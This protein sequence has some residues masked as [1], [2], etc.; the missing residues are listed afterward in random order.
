MQKITIIDAPCG[1]GK[2]S[3]AIQLMNQNTETRYIYCTPLLDEITRIK[4]NCPYKLFREPLNFE[5]RKIDDFNRLL[6]K[7]VNI[8]VTHHTLLNSTPETLELIRKGGYTLIL[9][10]ALDVLNDFNKLSSVEKDSRQKINKSDVALMLDTPL[11]EIDDALKVSWIGRTYPKGKFSAVE[12]LAKLGVLYCAQR[13]MMIYIFRPDLFECFN[14]ICVMT[15]LFEASFLRCYFDL[16]KIVYE[17]ESLVNE[18]GI[19][20]TVPY[21]PEI[22]SAFRSTCKRLITVCDCPRLNRGYDD[23]AFST[24]WFEKRKKDDEAIKRLKADLIYFFRYIADAR[25]S[26]SEI[27]WTCPKEN[28]E[29]VKGHSYTRVRRKKI[30]ET[31]TKKDEKKLD[32]FQPLNARGTNDFSDRWALA[33]CYNMF[34]NPLIKHFLRHHG[35]PMDENLF[36]VSCLIQW[37]FRGSIRDGK[38][39]ILYLPSPRMRRILQQWMD[40]EI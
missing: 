26:K 15:Y 8:A 6:T 27:L 9:D 22:D 30:K 17:R 34:L 16:H 1:A 21:D 10:E 12:Q 13:Q 14:E 40:G 28:Y 20:W 38:P 24:T 36:A 3:W 7:G 33:Y 37:I 35:I 29:M 11:I 18:N 5:T 39:I 23:N 25:A 32:C 4:E 2:T 31:L 19:Y